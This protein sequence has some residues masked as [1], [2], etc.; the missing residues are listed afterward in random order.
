MCTQKGGDEL[1]L[2]NSDLLPAVTSHDY[3]T[4]QGRGGPCVRE[5]ARLNSVYERTWITLQNALKQFTYIYH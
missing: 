1:S 3:V 5:T 4:Q 2:C